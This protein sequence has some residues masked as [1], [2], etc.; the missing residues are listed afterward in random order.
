MVTYN[1]PVFDL[2]SH[3]Q[4]GLLDI[5]GILSGS[6]QERDGQ[7]VREFLSTQLDRARETKLR[8]LTNLGNTVLHNLLACQI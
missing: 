7:L 3:C 8:S 5:G 1:I 2:L 4:E 6:L